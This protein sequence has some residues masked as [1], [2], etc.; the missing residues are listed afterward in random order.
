M[1]SKN[2]TYDQ[3]KYVINMSLRRNLQNY[4]VKSMIRCWMCERTMRVRK[5]PRQTNWCDIEIPS[6]RIMD[7]N[8][9]IRMNTWT[10][11]KNDN[12][13]SNVFFSNWRTRKR[14]GLVGIKRVDFLFRHFEWMVFATGFSISVSNG[15]NLWMKIAN[16]IATIGFQTQGKVKKSHTMNLWFP[17]AS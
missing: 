8:C 1:R 13:H 3:L 12:D 4:C 17:H 14:I 9:W 2:K 16:H 11:I 5:W 7:H 15:M 10:W 6:N